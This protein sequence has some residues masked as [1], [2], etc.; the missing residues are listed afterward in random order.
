LAFEGLQLRAHL[1]QLEDL[2][3]LRGIFGGRI[4]RPTRG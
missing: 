3:R 1:G 4:N 2:A